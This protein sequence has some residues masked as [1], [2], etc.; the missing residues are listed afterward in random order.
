[1]TTY[2]D[3]LSGKAIANAGDDSM[4]LIYGRASKFLDEA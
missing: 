3:F 4:D 1:L 2:K